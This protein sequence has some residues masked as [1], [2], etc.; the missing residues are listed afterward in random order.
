[1]FIQALLCATAVLPEG[2]WM[3]KRLEQILAGGKSSYSRTYLGGP[4]DTKVLDAFDASWATYGLDEN[5]VGE[6]R[7]NA[8][9]LAEVVYKCGNMPDGAP[10]PAAG[11][12]S[13]VAVAA[14]QVARAAQAA[15]DLD[16][17]GWS[18]KCKRIDVRE[19]SFDWNAF[20]E[21][22]MLRGIPAVLVG[23]GASEF[24][25]AAQKWHN[26]Q[27]LGKQ[28][29]KTKHDVNIFDSRWEQDRLGFMPTPATP[30]S[31][32]PDFP[33]EHTVLR[34]PFKESLPL[35]QLA[36]KKSKGF[37]AFIENGLLHR[38][39][40]EQPGAGAGQP[41]M[42][43]DLKIPPFLAQCDLDS[44]SFC[45]GALDANSKHTSQNSA[46]SYAASDAFTHQLSGKKTF[47]FFHHFDSPNMYP[48]WLRGVLAVQ[49][50]A[51][52]SSSYAPHGRI[53]RDVNNGTS[54]VRK[55]HRMHSPVNPHAPDL[56]KYPLFA[57]ARPMTCRAERGDTIYVPSHTWA[58]V[59]STHAPSEYSISFTFHAHCQNPEFSILASLFQDS[60][61]M[62]T[63][64]A[65]YGDY[66]P[67]SEKLLAKHP[68]LEAN[69][70]PKEDAA[71]KQKTQKKTQYKLSERHASL[72]AAQ[73]AGAD[74]E[75]DV[76]GGDDDEHGAGEFFNGGE[77]EEL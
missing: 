21:E 19:R 55:L 46:L 25:P 69:Q 59:N 47:T 22:H 30:E 8:Q 9:A 45:F 2:N 28:F 32:L 54:D 34:M 20:V 73:G 15:M 40:G 64:R 3:E 75:D 50:P 67:F 23:M 52:K 18:A 56:D 58:D 68:N 44:A 57:K 53:F 1:M 61:H 51:F 6:V 10:K 63:W 38:A 16:M 33:H 13:G 65:E 4:K 72:N 29:A 31:K 36:T 11:S 43:K 39:N 76:R 42:W 35:G 7:T 12:D 62:Q 27:Y 5:M 49:D 74:D 48:S 17:D 14:E 41:A 71:Q 66:P 60:L 24:G 26:A 37:S 77:R 70:A